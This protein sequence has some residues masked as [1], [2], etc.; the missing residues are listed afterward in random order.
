MVEGVLMA[1]TAVASTET[2]DV[3]AV[4]KWCAP[5]ET[6]DESSYVPRTPLGAR[7]TEIRKRIVASGQPLLDWDGIER[8][9]AERRGG[10]IKEESQ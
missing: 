2:T 5:A 7:L 4:R 3:A 1:R 6:F 10:V 9:V 8:E